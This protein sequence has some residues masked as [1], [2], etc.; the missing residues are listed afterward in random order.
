MNNKFLFDNKEEQALLVEW[1]KN[2]IIHEKGEAALLRRCRKVSEIYSCRSFYNL[3]SV[4]NHP[5]NKDNLAALVS[6]SA[7]VKINSVDYSFGHQMGQLDKSGKQKI[8]EV[9]FR[10]WINEPQGDELLISTIRLIRIIDS[11][12]NLVSMA[13]TIYY[14]NEHTRKK[15]AYDYFSAS[16]KQDQ[17]ELQKVH[18]E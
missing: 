2:L 17:N 14:W 16:E 15:I 6:I 8:K 10:K 12:V 3:I 18:G 7:H 13:Q 9:R 4:L 1:W 5:V 11:N